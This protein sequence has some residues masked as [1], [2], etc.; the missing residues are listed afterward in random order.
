MV[1]YTHTHIYIWTIYG[2]GFGGLTGAEL[3]KQGNSQYY[4]EMQFAFESW[5][6]KHCMPLHCLAKPKTKHSPVIIH[7]FLFLF[8][9]GLLFSVVFCQYLNFC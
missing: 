8:P 3:D 7:N 1:S 9:A 5:V 4:L 6:P 2:Y